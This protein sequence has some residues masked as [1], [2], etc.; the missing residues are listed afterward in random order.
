ML[1]EQVRIFTVTWIPKY[2]KRFLIT[3]NWKSEYDIWREGEFSGNSSLLQKLICIL[4]NY[5]RYLE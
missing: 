5:Y 3:L 4:K 1:A 2:L